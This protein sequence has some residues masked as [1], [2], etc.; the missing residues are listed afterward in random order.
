[1][2]DH[3]GSYLLNEVIEILDEAKVFDL[4]GQERSRALIL[5]ILHH[6]LRDYDC[7][8]GEILEGYEARFGICYYPAAA[9]DA[10]IGNIEAP[11]SSPRL[12]G[13]GSLCFPDW[14]LPTIGTSQWELPDI[15]ISPG[16]FGT[17]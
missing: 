14:L 17:R 2:S 13:G 15:P 10:A 9:Q 16:Y 5:K 6:A 4:L 1:M 3:A 8:A 11:W 12:P 7:N